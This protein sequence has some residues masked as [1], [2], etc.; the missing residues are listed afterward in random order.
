MKI[1]ILGARGM[2]GTE[3]SS[4]F[5]ELHPTLWDQ[6]D[7]D[8]TKTNLVEEKIESL[9]P[10]LII[11]AA[12]YTNVDESEEKQD[13][14]NR[15]NGEAVKSI[16]KIA[17]KIDATLIHYSTDYVFNGKK[18]KGY[19]EDEQ[20]DPINAYGNSKLLGENAITGNCTKYYLIRSSWL[21]SKHGKNF[22]ETIIKLGNSKKEVKVVNDQY[23]K[24]TYAVDL[25]KKTRELI[26][27]KK[28]FS[29]YHI[30]NEDETSWH[31]FAKE[32]FRQEKIDSNLVPIKSSQFPQAAKRP[33][34]SSLINTKV[35]PL[36]NW[37]EA[38]GSYLRSRN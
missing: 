34:Y 12:A 38:L 23:G 1:L 17:H 29:I 5:M 33:K 14:A 4:V 21:F 15:I 36:R 31:D 11:N 9:K 27:L 37:Q 22:V 26:E 16:A 6:E 25:A 30:T 35:P 18:K 10:G 3:L 8:I 28:E 13:I 2:L 20:T 32:I 7:L 19:K 24:P